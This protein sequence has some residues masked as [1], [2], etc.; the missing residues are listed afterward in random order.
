MFALIVFL[1]YVQIF[2]GIIPQYTGINLDLSHCLCDRSNPC[3][4]PSNETRPMKTPTSDS[5]PYSCPRD[6]VLSEAR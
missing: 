2:M 6:Q 5:N 3:H 4:G 1:E